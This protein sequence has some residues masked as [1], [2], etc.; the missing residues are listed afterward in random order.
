MAERIAPRQLGENALYQHGRGDLVGISP[1]L[2]SRK[3]PS[4]SV[5][6]TKVGVRGDNGQGVCWRLKRPG[7]L[8]FF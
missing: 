2:L 4:S 3:A 5:E 1:L 7:T 6:M 8:A